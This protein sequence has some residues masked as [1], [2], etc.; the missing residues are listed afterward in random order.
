MNKNSSLYQYA[1][2]YSSK[3]HLLF[4]VQRRPLT[5]RGCTT[6]S[7]STIWTARGRWDLCIPIL[8]H[9]YLHHAKLIIHHHHRSNGSCSHHACVI[10]WLER[11][12][13]MRNYLSMTSSKTC[14][15]GR[16]KQT[17]RWCRETITCI[18]KCIAIKDLPINYLMMET[19]IFQVLE[20]YQGRAAAHMDKI[21]VQLWQVMW[22][23]RMW[24]AQ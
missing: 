19:A 17:L 24:C 13:S 16:I 10:R 7:C 12:L 23:R 22:R 6:S 21:Q 11:I 15:H 9:M 5:V 18:H 8:K 4:G 1:I 3:L 2:L 14:L 20:H